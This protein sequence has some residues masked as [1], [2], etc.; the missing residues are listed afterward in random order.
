[1]LVFGLDWRLSRSNIYVGGVPLQS[2]AGLEVQSVYM[3]ALLRD[4]SMAPS[5]VTE[6]TTVTYSRDRMSFGSTMPHSEIPPQRL[7]LR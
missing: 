6:D 5:A 1:M 7:K 3:L 2:V 4:A